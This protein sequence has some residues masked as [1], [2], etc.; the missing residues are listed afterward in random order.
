[1]DILSEC[2]GSSNYTPE[3]EDT[4]ENRNVCPLLGFSRVSHHEGP[5]RGPQKTSA[6]SENSACADNEASRIGMDV[7]ST[8]PLDKG[9]E[10]TEGNVGNK[11]IGPDE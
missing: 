10:N 4:P 9:V 8:V 6:D 1:M 11:Q 5:L 7:Q 2:D 3:I